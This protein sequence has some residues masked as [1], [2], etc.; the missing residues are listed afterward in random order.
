MSVDALRAPLWLVILLVA[1]G[2][3]TAQPNA[4]AWCSRQFAASGPP[5]NV[6]DTARLVGSWNLV[7]VV[8]RGSRREVN[9]DSSQLGRRAGRLQ[10]STYDSR[11]N[12]LRVVG[13]ERDT[14]RAIGGTAEFGGF[15]GFRGERYWPSDPSPP[16]VLYGSTLYFGSPGGTDAMYDALRIDRWD[17]TGFAGWFHRSW[18][19][20]VPLGVTGEDLLPPTGYFCARKRTP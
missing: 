16:V 12:M 8:T 11:S 20:G 1:A 14:L 3:L 6:A 10:L 15:G 7:V 13:L 17:A 19:I 9:P 5:F 18:G 4:T 2:A